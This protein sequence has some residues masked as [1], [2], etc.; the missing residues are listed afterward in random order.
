MEKYIKQEKSWDDIEEVE[1]LPDEVLAFEAHR[2]NK[3][4]KEYHG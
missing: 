1:P 3:V 4:K 2:A